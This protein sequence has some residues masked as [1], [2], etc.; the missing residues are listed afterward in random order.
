MGFT[1]A[2]DQTL[3][4]YIVFILLFEENIQLDSSNNTLI[5]NSKYR[6][7]QKIVKYFFT[8]NKFNVVNLLL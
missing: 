8:E 5:Y 6:N 4:S 3:K 7:T 2:R 1:H